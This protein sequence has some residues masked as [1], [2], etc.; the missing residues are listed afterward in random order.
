MA[1]DV[2]R[3]I[4]S[5]S[6]ELNHKDKQQKQMNF[7]AECYK[8]A[9]VLKIRQAFSDGDYNDLGSLILYKLDEDLYIKLQSACSCCINS[10]PDR[11][12]CLSKNIKVLGQLGSFFKL[13]M[14][15]EHPHKFQMSLGSIQYQNRKDSRMIEKG[16]SPFHKAEYTHLT[17][18]VNIVWDAIV[19]LKGMVVIQE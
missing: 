3:C 1:D 9:Y 4:V 13:P 11:V 7:I 16:I 15:T 5:I 2:A 18:I 6:Q 10:K 12:I 17:P 8:N 19:L 14:N